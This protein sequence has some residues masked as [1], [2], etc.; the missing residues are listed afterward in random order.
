MDEQTQGALLLAVGLVTI[1][2]ALTDAALNFIR[3]EYVPLQFIA[4]GV[5]LV[6][7]ALTLRRAFGARNRSTATVAEDHGSDPLGVA[8]DIELHTSA[9]LGHGHDHAGGPRVA[10]MLAAP[11]FAIMLI[12]PPPL[13]AYAAGRQSGVIQSSAS[14]FAPLPPAEDGAVTLPLGAYSVRALYD[15]EKS[16]EGERIRLTGFVSQEVTDGVGDWL[17][18]RFALNCCAADG[19][20]INIAVEGGGPTPPIDQWVVVE[21]TWRNRDGHAI[22]DLTADPPIIVVDSVTRIPQPTQPYES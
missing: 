6:L 16:L 22:G 18:T 2:L 5:L 19:T 10:W 3:P 21:G 4:G 20:A 17:L 11:L 9:D 12:A 8:A 1:R 14:S 7:G 13:G 15:S